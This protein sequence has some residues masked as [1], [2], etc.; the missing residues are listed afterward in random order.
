MGGKGEE[1][2]RVR[3]V[4]PIILELALFCALCAGSISLGLGLAPASGGEKPSGLP[5]WFQAVPVLARLLPQSG[6]FEDLY[7]ASE[8]SLRSQAEDALRRLEDAR[9]EVRKNAILRLHYIVEIIPFADAGPVLE[10]ISQTDSHVDV[11]RRKDPMLDPFTIRQ[12][13]S[14][15]LSRLKSRLALEAW[16]ARY[17]T[18]E[19]ATKI[20]ELMSNRGPNWDYRV[21]PA[22][23]GLLTIWLRRHSAESLPLLTKIGSGEPFQ[24]GTDSFPIVETPNRAARDAAAY[25]IGITRAYEYVPYL[26]SLLDD[27]TCRAE[28]YEPPP[29]HGE[30]NSGP[31][32][33]VRRYPVRDS[34]AGALK[35][36]GCT[37]T[38]DGER[39]HVTPAQPP[40]TAPQDK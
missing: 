18:T 28:V 8:E 26:M 12:A 34:A 36:L 24:A 37:V 14:T 16:L 25:V 39:Y 13:A 3:L 40:A 29:R 21:A 35:H 27:P 1:T 23:D 19:Q 7:S 4:S 38:F 31:G 5:G 30:R 22:D 20:V 17:A 32:Q 10:Q 9:P 6:P 2:N 15:A 11:L 33:L